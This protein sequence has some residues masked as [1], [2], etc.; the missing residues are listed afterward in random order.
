MTVPADGNGAGPAIADPRTEF[1]GLAPVLRTSA[2]VSDAELRIA[3]AQL[4][5]WLEGVFEGAQ[6]AV[7]LHDAQVGGPWR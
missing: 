1:D 6:Y 7:A 3:E 4:V 5:G 2:A